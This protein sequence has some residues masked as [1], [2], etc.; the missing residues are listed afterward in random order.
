VIY[1]ISG[2]DD[3]PRASRPL[4]IMALCTCET[5]GAN[6]PALQHHI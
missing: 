5:W 3:A 1:I 6:K 2:Q 4:K